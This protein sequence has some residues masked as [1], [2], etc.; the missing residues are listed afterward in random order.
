MDDDYYSVSD[1]LKASQSRV[2]TDLNETARERLAHVTS[3]PR[4]KLLTSLNEGNELP[5]RF[6][7]TA[8]NLTY[9]DV[10]YSSI[11]EHLVFEAVENISGLPSG[12][13]NKDELVDI[14]AT[15]KEIIT[16][17]E[18]IPVLTYIEHLLESCV[19]SEPIKWGGPVVGDSKKKITND[20]IST[21]EKINV[22]L[23]T[24]GIL[25]ELQND[26][27]A[28]NFQPIGSELMVDAD[29]EF[30]IVASDRKWSSVVSPYQD[31]YRLYIDRVYS[32]EIPEKLYNSIEELAKTICV[33]LEEWEDNRELVLSNYLELM[34]ENEIFEQNNIMKEEITSL[35]KSM[36]LSFQKSGA[37]RKNRHKEIGREFCTLLLHQTSAYL[38][39]IIRKYENE[40]RQEVN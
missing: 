32:R 14:L 40:Y 34:R 36:E 39:Y 26:N 17:A 38:T 24:E 23:E 35:S 15:H 7:K 4:R 10:G 28:F 18:T 27:F 33:D 6:I 2:H 16:S 9:E 25:W 11:Q 31:A 21:K 22:I 13:M 12:D 20:I 29:E 8:I 19:H 37:E 30:S 1:R 5:G 3:N